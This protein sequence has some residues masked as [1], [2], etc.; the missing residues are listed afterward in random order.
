MDTLPMS[1]VL[2]LVTPSLH[3]LVRIAS[4]LRLTVQR[5]AQPSFNTY[6]NLA[7]RPDGLALLSAT[8][9]I[10]QTGGVIGTLTLF[11]IEPL[12]GKSSD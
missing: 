9:G 2:R 12:D 1:L 3:T 4:V 6:F 10:F 11:V 5:V 7:D 8:N